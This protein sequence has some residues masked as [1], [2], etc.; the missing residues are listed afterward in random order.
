MGFDAKK[1]RAAALSPRTADVPVPDLKP[2][3]DDG[4]PAVW[5]VKGLTGQQLARANEAAAR[6]NK[7]AA[8]FEDIVGGSQKEQVAAVKQ[9][10]GLGDDTPQDIAKRIYMLVHG[11]VDPECDEELAVKLFR[12]FPIEAYEITNTIIKITGQGHIPGK[13]SGSGKAPV[14]E[15]V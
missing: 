1:F 5:R 6:N 10:L 11:S 13:A 3:F 2:W 15:P 8:L 4:D 9:A 14:S 7:I 12:T